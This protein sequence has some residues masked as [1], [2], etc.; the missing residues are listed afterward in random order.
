[1]LV[2]VVRE[3]SGDVEVV[4][5]QWKCG[6]GRSSNGVVVEETKKKFGGRGNDGG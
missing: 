1:M 5:T 4:A 6:N 3:E 2:R